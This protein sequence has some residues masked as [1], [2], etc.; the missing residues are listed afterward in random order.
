MNEPSNV[1]SLFV[2]GLRASS[3]LTIAS[4]GLVGSSR[5]TLSRVTTPTSLVFNIRPLPGKLNLAALSCRYI[6]GFNKARQATNNLKQPELGVP[7]LHGS[8]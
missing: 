5:G 6:R 2:R 4:T 8:P 7:E 3:N 1:E